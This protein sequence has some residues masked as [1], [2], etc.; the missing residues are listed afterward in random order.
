[1]GTES[2]NAQGATVV[3]VVS[4][5]AQAH[6]SCIHHHSIVRTTLKRQAPQ[7]TSVAALWVFV[8][9]WLLYMTFVLPLALEKR[10]DVTFSSVYYC[11]KI[12]SVD[13]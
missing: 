12:D 10:M 8:P 4:R 13:N 3:S 1:M 11:M 9:F 7:I 5:C 2:G 6:H